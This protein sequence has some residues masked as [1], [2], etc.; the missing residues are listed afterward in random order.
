VKTYGIDWHN[1]KTITS[2]EEH[3]C[4]WIHDIG[5]YLEVTSEEQA[6]HLTKNFA[7]PNPQHLFVFS[8]IVRQAYRINRGLLVEGQK[9]MTLKEVAQHTFKDCRARHVMGASKYGEIGFLSKQRTTLVRDF[10]EEICDVINYDIYVDYH[11]SVFGA[12]K[13]YEKTEEVPND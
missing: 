2:L 11:D 10:A 7:P 6:H 12:K 13:S 9:L 3:I 8:L 5:N 1:Q 4:S